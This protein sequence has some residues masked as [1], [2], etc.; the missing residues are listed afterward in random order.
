MQYEEYDRQGII[1]LT[2]RP[3]G[4]ETYYR[5]DDN[6]V[7]D[8]DGKAIDSVLSGKSDRVLLRR[9]LTVQL[10]R[11]R[12]GQR[13]NFQIVLQVKMCTMGIPRKR[14]HIW[15]TFS[16]SSSCGACSV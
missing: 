1:K 6:N 16:Y 9:L 3:I 8:N 14:H 13:H 7:T 15:H 12:L 5:P 11:T 2:V 4:A 10:I